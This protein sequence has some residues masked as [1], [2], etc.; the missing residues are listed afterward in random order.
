[1]IGDSHAMG[2]AAQIVEH[3]FRTAERSFGVHHT[4]TEDS[5]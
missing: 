5:L 4:S 2:V 3:M 1:M